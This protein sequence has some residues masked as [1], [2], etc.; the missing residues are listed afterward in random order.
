MH[1]QLICVGHNQ[2]RWVAEGTQEYQKRFGRVWPFSLVELKPEKRLEGR[3][4]DG[5]L[6]L[7]AQRITAQ[8]PRGAALVAL[9]ERGESLTSRQLADRLTEMAQQTSHASFVIGSADGLDASL[10]ASAAWRW[11]LS[12][13]TFPHGLARVCAVEQL[14]RAVSL[15][16]GLPYHRD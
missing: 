4:V 13:L 2:P 5:L 7:E 3:A 15:I 14:Y 9:D 8:I 10:R 16:D 12:K 1:L 6:A 11:S